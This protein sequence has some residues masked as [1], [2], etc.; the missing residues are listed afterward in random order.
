MSIEILVCGGGQ[1]P[2]KMGPQR[3]GTRVR[4]GGLARDLRQNHLDTFT[5]VKPFKMSYIWVH[6]QHN[7]A[8]VSLKPV[9]TTL[10]LLILSNNQGTL[11][12]A[13][14]KFMGRWGTKLSMEEGTQIFLMGG[15]GLY[16][17]QASMGGQ[18]LHGV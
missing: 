13:R 12:E 3:E 10:F 14:R 11:Q 16:G 4:W 1:V 7:E 5:G 6:K 17:G 8:N 18:P 15:T 2:H 9:N